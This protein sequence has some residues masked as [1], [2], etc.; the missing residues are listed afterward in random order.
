MVPAFSWAHGPG[1]QC[2]A[3]CVMNAPTCT[4]GSSRARGV[5]GGRAP[6]RGAMALLSHLPNP[7]APWHRGAPGRSYQT[8]VP[9]PG[10]HGT[11]GSF[12]NTN[13]RSRTPKTGPRS[14]E[15][16]PPTPASRRLCVPGRDRGEGG[17]QVTP[18][19]G[20]HG[21][22]GGPQQDHHAHRGPTKHEACRGLT[23]S[24]A[25]QRHSEQPEPR[26]GHGENVDSPRARKSR[27][28]QSCVLGNRTPRSTGTLLCSPKAFLS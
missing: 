8:W 22:P 26:R 14:P 5:W 11:S 3:S 17:H 24:L 23:R 27:R 12:G 6:V 19:T 1:T 9:F 4:A 13:G 25:P 21:V 20:S 15:E 2:S 10:V 16:T 28:P 18:R 7:G